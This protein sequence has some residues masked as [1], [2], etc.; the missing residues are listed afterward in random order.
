MPYFKTYLI[1]YTL[2]MALSQLSSAEPTPQPTIEALHWWTT[3]GEAKAL[4]VIKDKM[5]QEGYIWRDSTIR[6][7]NGSEQKRVLR[8][9]VEAH[10]PPDIVQTQYIKQFYREG[11]LDNLDNI[12][13]KDHWE[14]IIP[15]PIQ[16]SVRYQGH[17]LAVPLNIQRSNWIWANK[18]IFD[19]LHLKPPKTFNELIE[20]SEKIKRAGYIPF[21]HGGQ[22]WQDIIFFDAVLLS[23]GGVS[24]Y[25][26]A[27]IDFDAETLKSPQMVTVFERTLKLRNF[28]D[29]DFVGRDWNLATAMLIHDK[30]AMQVMGDWVKGEFNNAHL[31]SGKDYFCFE[32]PETFGSFLYSS[33]MFSIIKAPQKQRRSQEDL[34]RIAISKEVQETFNLAKGSTPVRLDVNMK[35]FDECTQQAHTHFMAAMKK[36]QVIER[37][38]IIPSLARRNA[39]FNFIGEFIQKGNLGAKEA[40]ERFAKIIQSTP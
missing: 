30:A 13:K 17:W 12:A 24:L 1:L 36:N 18:K 3:G 40:A 25:Q 5:A 9:R 4:K 31:E 29:S 26:K 35:L 22:P 39:I 14:T 6:E 33:D 16:N 34:A 8:A 38:D 2:G 37:F 19:K 23:V 27:L 15:K 20:V 21:A 7:G 32:Y 10:T 28:F 11:F